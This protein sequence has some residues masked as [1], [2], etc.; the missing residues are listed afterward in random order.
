[1][2]V[3]KSLSP[4]LRNTGLG[5]VDGLLRALVGDL[6]SVHAVVMDDSPWTTRRPGSVLLCWSNPPVGMKS[7]A[8]TD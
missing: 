1:V 3:V 5:A 6:D 7:Q 2:Q 4:R 8:L